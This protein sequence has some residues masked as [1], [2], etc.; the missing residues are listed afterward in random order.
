MK[1]EEIEERSFRNLVEFNREELIKIT[2]GTRASELF[3]D[4]ERMR[5]KLH[6]VLA[7]RD[8]RK[9]VPTARAMAVLNGEEGVELDVA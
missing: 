5:L 6:G 2:E 4:R 1:A 9:S 3:N 7:R 8:G